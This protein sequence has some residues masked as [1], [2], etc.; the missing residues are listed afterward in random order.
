MK[1]T[2]P[3]TSL[4][5]PIFEREKI[6]GY[7]DNFVKILNAASMT[8]DANIIQEVA[9]MFKPDQIKRAMD[10]AYGYDSNALV[11]DTKRSELEREA[12]KKLDEV[13]NKIMALTG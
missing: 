5:L 10:L 11:A 13:T 12:Q 4:S 1:V 7:L 9:K 3:S 8:Q 6:N 2:T